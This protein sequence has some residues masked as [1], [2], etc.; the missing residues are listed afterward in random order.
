MEAPSHVRLAIGLKFNLI[1]VKSFY[2]TEF[3]SGRKRY[4]VNCVCDC[5]NELVARLD[6]IKAGNKKHCGCVKPKRGGIHSE[7]F[8][9]DFRRDRS[10]MF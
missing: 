3:T 8:K 5:G 9:I 6:S 2:K 7:K 1:T 10:K 4:L